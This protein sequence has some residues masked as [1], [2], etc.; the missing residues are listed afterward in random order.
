MLILRMSMYIRVKLLGELFLRFS[1]RHPL[2]YFQSMKKDL[3]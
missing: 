3:C 2:E 1:S